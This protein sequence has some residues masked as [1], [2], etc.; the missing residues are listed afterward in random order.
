MQDQHETSRRV[1]LGSAAAMTAASYSRVLGANERVNI[2]FIGYGLIGRQHMTDFKKMPDVNLA[3]L[4]DVYAPRMD[5]GIAYMGNPSAK[6]YPD[7]RKMLDDKE[8]EG[9]VVATPDHWHALITI[10]ACAAGKD[11]YV[12]K[13]LTV[14]VEE[15]RWMVK[16]AR[17]Y[18]RMVTVGT[19]RR[20]GRGV[21]AA[22]EIISSGK[23]GKVHSVRISSYRNVYPGFGKTPVGTP[24]QELDYEMWQGP[25]PK[26]PYTNHRALY[27]FRWFWDYS[28]GQMTNL[29]AHSM[30]QMH[31]IM[32]VNA[33]TLVSSHGGRYILEDDGETPDLQDALF[34]YPGF[35]LVYSIREGAAGPRDPNSFAPQYFG[36]KGTLMMRGDAQIVPEMKSNPDNLIPQFSGH[37]IGGPKTT[38]DKPV[39]WIEA[40]AASSERGA[41]EDTMTLN[42]RDWLGSMRSRKLPFCDVEG[43]HRVATATHL[44]N[45]SLRLGTYGALG[46][47]KGD[48]PRRQ[49]S[50]R[51]ARPALSQA[52]GPGAGEFQALVHPQPRHFRR[53]RSKESPGAT[54]FSAGACLGRSAGYNPEPWAESQPSSF[55]PRCFSHS[56]PRRAFRT[57]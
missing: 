19:Q 23:L 8:I 46:S 18:N 40:P 53:R 39:P 24:P 54:F 13:P 9:V 6:R 7:F 34:T 45:I 44:A 38:P 25:A 21:A 52:L 2:G 42:K 11:V 49:R 57:P 55:S 37:P 51:D 56:S 33:P 30:D 4:S 41:P 14:F 43:G 12:E 50:R 31:Y 5:E 28:G 47:G 27:H 26:R 20:T 3:A 48:H 10:M 1:F 17:K 32:G 16:A 22:K 36:N 35:T 29:A 15:G